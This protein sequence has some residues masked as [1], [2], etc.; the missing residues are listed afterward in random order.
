MDQSVANTKL[1][2]IVSNFYNVQILNNI[3]LIKFCLKLFR[4]K[5]WRKIAK[6]F[7]R[8][9]LRQAFAKARDEEQEKCKY[10]IQR[11][12]EICIII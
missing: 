10:Y 11:K 5:E 12:D 2:Y 4:H 9:R 7:R 6:K 1:K 8:K 3:I